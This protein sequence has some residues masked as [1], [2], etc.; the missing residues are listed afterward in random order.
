MY[1]RELYK[2]SKCALWYNHYVLSRSG[3]GERSM[4]DTIT[5]AGERVGAHVRKVLAKLKALKHRQRA[6]NGPPN[7]SLD[8][9]VEVDREDDASEGI[10]GVQRPA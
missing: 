2:L 10:G 1:N 4:A 8:S 6:H 7:G 9:A 3:P 5:D